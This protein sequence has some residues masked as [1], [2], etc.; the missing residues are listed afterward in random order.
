MSSKR[1]SAPSWVSTKAGAHL[2]RR[3]KRNTAPELLLR[4]AL[5]AQG[6][7]FRLHRRLAHGCTPDIVLPRFRVAVF[8]DGCFW[9]GCPT[10]GRASFSGPNA[11]LWVDKMLTNKQRDERSTGLAVDAGWTVLRIWECQV[12]DDAHAAAASVTA[13][14]ARQVEG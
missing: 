7:R 14:C 12:N 8:V 3:R 6:F 11:N 10:H 9:H 4:S 2:R 13:K 1:T 5:H